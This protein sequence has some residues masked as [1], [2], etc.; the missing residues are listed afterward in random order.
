MLVRPKLNAWCKFGIS[1]YYLLLALSYPDDELAK[2]LDVTP[3]TVWNWKRGVSPVPKHVYEYLLVYKKRI[4]PASWESFAGWRLRPDGRL[5]PPGLR[6]RGWLAHELPSQNELA[7]LTADAVSLA[8][9]NMKL[10]RY[11]DELEHLIARLG[12]HR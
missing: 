10:K 6:Q 3:R 1:N 11:I 5:T 12:G 2:L 8:R 7:R 9:E 4:L